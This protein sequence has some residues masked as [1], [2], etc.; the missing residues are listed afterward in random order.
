MTNKHIFETAYL[1]QFVDENIVDGV[2]AA[3]AVSD[4]ASDPRNIAIKARDGRDLL[5]IT[6]YKESWAFEKG[7]EMPL[8]IDF[9]EG[10]P[11]TLTGYGDGKVLNATL[12]MSDAPLFLHLVASREAVKLSVP[13]LGDHWLI[14][15]R[16]APPV[17]VKFLR[18]L[19]GDS[20]KFSKNSQMPDKQKGKGNSK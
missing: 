2:F 19:M 5:A 4:N 10:K 11:E 1:W 20:K 12:P 14:D 9:F 15:L 8:I 7:D 17:I 6:L 3:M 13:R 18:R 16:F